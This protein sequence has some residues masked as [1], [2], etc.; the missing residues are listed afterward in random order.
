MMRRHLGY[1]MAGAGDGRRPTLRGIARDRSAMVFITIAFLGVAAVLTRMAATRLELRRLSQESAAWPRVSG[2][3]VDIRPVW[4]SSPRAGK[5]YWPTIHYRYSVG[6]RTFLGDRVSFRPTYGR[7]EA[8]NAVSRFPAGA[9]VSVWYRP[10]DPGTS[11]LEPSTCRTG[12]TMIF[13][14]PSAVVAL[15]LALF[16]LAILLLVSKPRG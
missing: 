14:V 4:S 7:A 15:A 5:A 16:C 6:G 1:L 2:E 8:E 13:L 11:V 3:V 12:L 9:P 10:R